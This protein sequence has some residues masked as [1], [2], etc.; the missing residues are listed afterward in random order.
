MNG[1]K[2]EAAP[3]L[4][5]FTTG[6]F[7]N[8]LRESLTKIHHKKYLLVQNGTNG[9]INGQVILE[10]H[11]GWQGNSLVETTSRDVVQTRRGIR[12]DCSTNFKTKFR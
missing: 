7:D 4:T 1:K 6:T 5:I 10:Q 8:L 9:K 12:T 11:K 3:E 2:Q